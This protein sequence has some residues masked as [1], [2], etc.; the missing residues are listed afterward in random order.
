VTTEHPDI[1]V[2]EVAQIVACK[3]KTLDKKSP[4]DPLAYLL[5][6]VRNAVAGN[7]LSQY[8]AWFATARHVMGS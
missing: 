2:A 3:R 1:T 6:S 4:G 7:G 5:A 8:R